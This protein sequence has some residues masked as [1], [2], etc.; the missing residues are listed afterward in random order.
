MANSSLN[1]HES[2]ELEALELFEAFMREAAATASSGLAAQKLSG[3]MT[4]KHHERLA[5]LRSKAMGTTVQ[6]PVA[7]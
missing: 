7:A 3:F 6:E 4:A 1:L 5:H 2:A